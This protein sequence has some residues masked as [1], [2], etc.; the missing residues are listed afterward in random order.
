MN[1]FDRIKKSL[2]PHIN[3]TMFFFFFSSSNPVTITTPHSYQSLPLS[4]TV[5]V[6]INKCD[7]LLSGTWPM[8]WSAPSV[9]PAPNGH[10]A[11]TFQPSPRSKLH[12]SWPW[13]LAATIDW[14]RVEGAQ[15]YWLKPM[16][17]F[18]QI[19][20]CAAGSAWFSPSDT[21]PHDI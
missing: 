1:H 8:A 17:L 10:C 11:G 13:P 19:C 5:Y 21:K 20:L 14:K 4:N 9:T 16:Q 12:L 2:R 15:W 18:L 3:T 7:W 6:F